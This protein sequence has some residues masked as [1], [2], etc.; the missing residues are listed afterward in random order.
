MSI[1]RAQIE[2]ALELTE[3]IQRVYGTASEQVKRGYNQPSSS[4]ST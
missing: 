2:K 3:D 1:D 4:N